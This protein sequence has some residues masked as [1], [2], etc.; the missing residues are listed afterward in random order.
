MESAPPWRPHHDPDRANVA[1]GRQPDLGK[2]LKG[3]SSGGLHGRSRGRKWR[4]TIAARRLSEDCGPAYTR[5]PRRKQGG[6]N[7]RRAVL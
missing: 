6:S 4:R 7:R 5:E 2:I 3:A 1:R